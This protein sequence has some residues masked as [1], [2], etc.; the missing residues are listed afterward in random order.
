MN[1]LEFLTYLRKLD[2]AVHL[3][4]GRLRVDGPKEAL[5]SNLREQ[6]ALRKTDIVVFL[7]DTVQNEQPEL[8]S[9]A[10]VSRDG[11][12][13]LSFAQHRLWF[14]DQLAPES[15]AYVMP[16]AARLSGRLDIPA[17]EKSLAMIAHRHESLRTVFASTDGTPYQVILNAATLPL[18][19]TDLGHLPVEERRREADRLA[20][21][22]AQTPFDL[23]R[24]PLW[25]AQLVRLGQ[26]EHI[27]L[28]AIHHIVSDG[29]SIAV[30]IREMST[31][32]RAFQSGEP[33][34]LAELPIQYVDFSQWQRRC[35][36][37]G[38]REKH[39]AYW[40][41]QLGGGVP[42][43]EL[44][45]DR[46]RSVEQILRS[47][48]CSL[49]LP[50]ELLEGLKALS[51][52]EGASLFMTLLAAFDAL[53]YR[54]TGQEDI[55][56]GTPVAGRNR[57]E[58]EGLIGFFINTV[59][60]RADFGEERTFRELL[61]QVR[62]TAL[63]AYAHQDMPFEELVVAVDPKRDLNRTPIFQV[64][65]NHLNLEIPKMQIAGLTAEP[66]GEM[67][68]E[69]KFDLTL[70][71]QER[72]EGLGLVLVYNA[73]L[74]NANRMQGLLEQY[75]TLLEQIAR[76]PDCSV[77]KYSLITPSAVAVLPDPTIPL[78]VRWE[79]SVVERF[80]LQ[81]AER[82][83]AVAVSE[84]EGEWTYAEL[85][86]LSGGLA[87]WLGRQGIG[88][89]D[90]VAIYGHRSAPLV[91]AMLG[92]LRAGAAFCILDPA[93]PAVRLC[94]SV[95]AVQP[96]CLLQLAQAGK[97][98]EEL[99]VV[100][101]KAVEEHRLELPGMAGVKE[102]VELAEPATA[103]APIDPET[104]A[105]LTFTSGTTGEAK[106]V[107]GT[108]RPL[109]HFLEWHCREFGLEATD[110]FSLLS[111]LAHDPLLRDVFTPL[112]IG[113]TLCIP[114]PETMFGPGGL[115]EWM[116]RE[117][118][119][120]SH[121]TP[122]MGS[123][124][125]EGVGDQGSGG[126][127]PRL[128]YAFFGGDK[129]TVRNAGQVRGLAPGVEIVNYYGATE[130]PQAM[131]WH[132]VLA[133]EMEEWEKNPNVA[134]RGIAIGRGIGEVQILVV[135]RVR[136]RAAV[137]ELGE[138]YVRTPYLSQG[139]GNDPALTRER[140]VV[141]PFTGKAEDRLYR[142]G[143]LGRY[144]PEG[145]VEVA[146]RA[147]QQVKVRGYRV[148]LGEVEA[149][150]CA[151]EQIREAV[152]VATRGEDG[153]NRLIA[154][155]VAAGVEP[156]P[157]ELRAHLARWLPEYMMPAGM[158]FVEAIPLTPNGKVDHAALPSPEDGSLCESVAYTPPRTEVER[159]MVGIWCEVLEVTKVGVFDNFFELGG[160]SLSATRL[161][162]RLKST[163]QVELPL[164]SIFIDPT[165][166]ELAKHLLYDTATGKYHYVG[167]IR[168][169][170]RMIPAQPKGS[171]TPFYLVAGYMDEDDTLRVLARIFPHVGLDQPMYGFQPRWL[172]GQSEGYSSVEDVALE[173]LAE[174]RAFQPEGPYL[175]GGDCVGGIVALEM[176]RELL[177]QGEEVG[178]LVMMDTERTTA[179]RAL[180]AEL[181]IAWRR[182]GHILDVLSQVIRGRPRSR[183]QLIQDLVRRKFKTKTKA[184]LIKAQD[185]S[186]G[187]D[188]S[189]VD[190]IYQ[191]RMD[192]RRMIYRHRVKPYSGR[193]S[194]ML[195]ERSYRFNR[196]MGWHRIALGGLEIHS[197]PGDHWTRYTVHS[198]EFAKKL[199]ECLE[200]AQSEGARR[201]PSRDGGRLVNKGN[202][203]VHESKVP[204]IVAV[205][206]MGSSFWF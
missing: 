79:G 131:G 83:E 25:R 53:L 30:L 108:H 184:A 52:R 145:L 111:G 97:L 54:L 175:L 37:E 125:C 42:M 183:V 162:A 160:H 106:C 135:N 138:I 115:A 17:L 169:W 63:E 134:G 22:N 196:Q 159:I 91:L 126:M 158:V 150:L 133:Q 48:N 31:L 94:G 74:F 104:L 128:R 13:P 29:W 19:V 151:H 189:A 82:P 12:I 124:M 186:K 8:S 9:I 144:T 130:T 73:D 21:A 90:V 11:R 203:P 123:L 179:L 72:G 80:L 140:F 107:M 176:A 44:P 56:V 191:S 18:P 168:R 187:Q 98:A 69:S 65:F 7:R 122:A 118:I 197:T 204:L 58:T 155:A 24:G 146:G 40:K 10:R 201:R 185:G 35:L 59:V 174:L 178:L 3:Q 57:A 172:D 38:G 166:A 60:M 27:L 199:L 95:E 103:A 71:V 142:T 68:L 6:L 50:A 137:G 206:L 153:N 2:I 46:P 182:G 129:L 181:R 76:N 88:D 192:Y 147:D 14:L 143:D 173:F 20:A 96:K 85:E 61:R 154:Y 177:R 105:Y 23:A 167:K 132:R 148:E 43:L 110:R 32:Y 194:L 99:E 4:D 119:T 171:R 141:N 45:T 84:P 28:F 195:N 188:A 157:G 15:K 67:V 70:Y 136:E 152:V 36:A 16:I 101:R 77:E 190:R 193:V 113:G 92:V 5:T 41:E 163:L 47:D 200:R 93:Y 117:Q 198:K 116:K 49:E 180:F 34:P 112:W 156:K 114:D 1:T 66:F 81:A 100:M 55:I 120:V 39:L 149:V 78:E 165:I 205:F 87:G 170:N 202:E 62:E 64:F 164:N 121:L 86:R 127:L 109:S 75:Q 26:D 139:Y 89:G 102:M 51:Q 33:S 161:I